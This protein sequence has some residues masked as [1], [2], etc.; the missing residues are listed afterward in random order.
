MYIRCDC[1]YVRSS[2][3]R[4]TFWL[5]GDRKR[6]ICLPTNG[7]SSA[8]MYTIPVFFFLLSWKAFFSDV[9]FQNL[10][11]PMPLVPPIPCDG[12]AFARSTQNPIIYSTTIRAL[13]VT[14]LCVCRAKL[15][16][17]PLFSIYI[18]RYI[19]RDTVLSSRW[20]SK[21]DSYLF[22]STAMS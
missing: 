2:T 16:N 19:D 6:F 3:P 18:P 22:A 5:L 17:Q 11:K 1:L 14:M 13:S 8:T 10:G 21:S 4:G 20:S 7:K 15:Y 9:L 12:Y